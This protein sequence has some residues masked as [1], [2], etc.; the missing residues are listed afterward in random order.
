LWHS[1]YKTQGFERLQYRYFG[2]IGRLKYTA[3]IIE[4]YLSGELGEIAELE[5]EVLYS[6]P[7]RSRSAR[8]FMYIT[9]H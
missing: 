5:P 8:E 2:A 3:E 4:K 1:D 7:I 9:S 6:N